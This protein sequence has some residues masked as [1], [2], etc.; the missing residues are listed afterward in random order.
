M[1]IKTFKSQIDVFKQ[2]FSSLKERFDY[3]PSIYF[4]QL[5]HR[6]K[7]DEEK[8]SSLSPLA[9]LKEAMQSS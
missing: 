5:F 8:L 3:L 1:L 4:E 9:V 2:R 6:L 7:I